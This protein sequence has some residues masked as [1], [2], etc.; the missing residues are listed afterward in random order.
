[1]YTINIKHKIYVMIHIS[2][3]HSRVCERGTGTDRSCICE[4]EDIIR[5]T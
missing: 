5:Y 1:M 4:D 2:E 3:I